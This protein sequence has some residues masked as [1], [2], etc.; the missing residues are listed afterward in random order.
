MSQFG[1][2]ISRSSSLRMNLLV[3]VQPLRPDPGRRS[4]SGEISATPDS[5][6]PRIKQQLPLVAGYRPSQEPRGFL[7]GFR[8]RAGAG[9]RS[10]GGSR[11]RPLLLLCPEQLETGECQADRYHSSMAVIQVRGLFR[12]YPSFTTLEWWSAGWSGYIEFTT[13]SKNCHYS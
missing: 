7:H 3:S 9:A 12:N 8:R 2:Y 13:S 5:I 6:E 10:Q 4:P 1:G 11:S